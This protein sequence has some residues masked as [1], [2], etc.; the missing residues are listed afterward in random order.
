MSSRFIEHHQ[1]TTLLGWPTDIL[2][3]DKIN[4]SAAGEDPNPNPVHTIHTIII[5]IPG[6]PGQYN[7]Y[8]S[9]FRDI[10]SG[11]GD[12]YSLH[13]CRRRSCHEE[14]ASASIPWTVDGQVLHKIAYIDSLLLLIKQHSNHSR[15]IPNPKFIWMGHS[16]GCHIIQ[17]ICVLRK[18]ILKRTE[19]FLFLMPYIRTFPNNVI[20][21]KNLNFCGNNQN[22]LINIGTRLSQTIRLLPESVVRNLIRNGMKRDD[23]EITNLTTTLL[24]QPIYPQNFLQLGT[25][26]IRDIPNEIDV[27]ALRLL[28]SSSSSNKGGGGGERPIF[29]L[30]AGDNDQW[31]PYFHGE[32][33]ISLQSVNVLPSSIKITKIPGLRHDYVCQNRVTRSKVN[34][35]CISNISSVNNTNANPST[36]DDGDCY[37]SVAPNTMALA[38]KL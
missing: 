36:S 34:D 30:Y 2:S 7:W 26:E 29:I 25:E 13:H 14:S 4:I 22:H 19:G 23:D 33:I 38:S 37:R 6:N 32:E 31:C 18:D 35:W 9:D 21:Q 11:L 8:N 1:S 17:R 10:L 3:V 5:H 12:G 15:F 24:R 20:D 16:F 28:S 27:T